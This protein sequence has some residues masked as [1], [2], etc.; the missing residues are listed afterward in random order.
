MTTNALQDVAKF[1]ALKKAWDKISGGKIG[2]PGSDTQGYDG[3][4]LTSFLKS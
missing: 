1:A 2:K 4:S 3:E